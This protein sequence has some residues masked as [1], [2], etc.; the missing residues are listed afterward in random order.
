MLISFLFC[1]AQTTPQNDERAIK[2]RELLSKADEGY[3]FAQYQIGQYYEDGRYPVSKDFQKA[4][5][6]YTKSANQKL[7]EA[8]AK[9]GVIWAHKALDHSPENI[10]EYI[11]WVILFH[12]LDSSVGI[13]YSPSYFRSDSGFSDASIAEGL[14]R[15]QDFKFT[16]EGKGGFLVDRGDTIKRV[17]RWTGLS[18][19]QLKKLNP[20][21]DFSRLTIGQVLLTK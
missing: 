6:Y 11:K 8:I 3:S 4:E 9:L 19:D 13:K 12:S 7:R 21:V 16:M 2:F 17:E 15:A 10:R 18:E 14:R 20:S 1:E 5:E